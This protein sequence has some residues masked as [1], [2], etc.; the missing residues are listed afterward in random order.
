MDK[1]R[2]QISSL[3]ICGLYRPDLSPFT[4][5]V[6]GVMQQQVYRTP[7]RNVDELKKRPEQNIIDTAINE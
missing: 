6:C 1:K 4:Y 2:Q 5:N 7:F 3:R